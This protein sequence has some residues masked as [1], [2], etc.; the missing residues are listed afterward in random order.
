MER[1]VMIH[2]PLVVRKPL[3]FWGFSTLHTSTMGVILTT[4]DWWC[5]MAEVGFERLPRHLA[6]IMDGNGR[7]AKIRSLPRIE[8]HRKGAESVRNVVRACRRF[9]IE[10]LT[11]YAFSLEN[12]KRPPNEVAA[13]MDLL[14]GYLVSERQEMV[15]NGIRLHVIGRRSDL[16]RDIQNILQ[17]TIDATA[18]NGDMHLNLA[19]SYSGRS[20]ILEAFKRFMADVQQGSAD[21]PNLTE[22]TFSEYLDTRGLPEPDLLIRTSGEKRISNFLLWQLA[23]TEIHFTETLWPDFSE[24]QLIEALRDYERRER[25]FGRISEQVRSL[26]P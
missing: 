8:G 25:R 19:L 7:W 18:H 24:A 4:Q 14:K 20:E 5:S 11:L 13:L 3:K 2:T 15:E 10:V 9:G 1:R 26:L 17:E 16:T 21:P 6:I 12:W 23:Y 22:E